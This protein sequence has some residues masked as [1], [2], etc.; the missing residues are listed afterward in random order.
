MF[1]V[2]LCD[3]LYGAYGVNIVAV[4]LFIA[5]VACSALLMAISSV[6][7]TEWLSVSLAL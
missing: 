5:K 3:G 1:G 7:Y 6:V 4:G 2:L